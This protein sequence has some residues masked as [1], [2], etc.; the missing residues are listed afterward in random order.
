MEYPE[1]IYATRDGGFLTS[2]Q[3]K[4]AGPGWV[5]HHTYKVGYEADKAEQSNPLPGYSN[6]TEAISAGEPIDWERLDGKNVQVVNPDVGSLEG[7][8]KRDPRFSA[9]LPAG[10]WHTDMDRVYVDACVKGWGGNGGWVLWI[11][12]EI[13]MRR[14]TADQ[15]PLGMCFEGKYHGSRIELAQVIANRYGNRL[16]TDHAVKNIGGYAEEEVEVIKEYGIGTFQE[17]EGK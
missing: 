16:V 4:N 11:E 7:E 3:R 17:P 8:F 5:C 1:E 13:P 6:L 10:W 14:K 9:D 15:L 2:K 12:G